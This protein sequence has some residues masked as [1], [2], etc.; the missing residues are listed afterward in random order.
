MGKTLRFLSEEIRELIPPTLFFL[1][2]FHMLAMTQAMARGE[3]GVGMLRSVAATIGALT[4]GKAVLIVDALPIG[5]RFD[6]RPLAIGILW[7][8][9]L[10]GLLTVLFHY[11]EEVLPHVRE[12][13]FAGAHRHAF[14]EASG[15]RILVVQA[16]L[17]GAMLLYAGV[18]EVI[19]H[20]GWAT[21]KDELFHRHAPAALQGHRE[22]T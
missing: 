19:R 5:R 8:A 4:V 21:V 10:F 22:K 11:L 3:H 16:W 15:S 17:W 9:L 13:G 7:K 1:V 18:S 2:V 12:L 20:Y 6:D 14:A